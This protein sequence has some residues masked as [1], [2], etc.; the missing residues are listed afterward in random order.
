MVVALDV[1]GTIVGVFLLVTAYGMASMPVHVSAM[2]L[3][4]YQYCFRLGT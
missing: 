4:R 3:L 1:F 2:E